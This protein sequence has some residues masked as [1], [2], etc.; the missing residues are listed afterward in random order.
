MSSGW[1][2]QLRAGI[3]DACQSMIANSLARYYGVAYA[4]MLDL[5]LRSVSLEEPCST[6]QSIHP[7]TDSDHLFLY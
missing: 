4:E 1:T 2:E 6:L 3:K 7:S 5:V